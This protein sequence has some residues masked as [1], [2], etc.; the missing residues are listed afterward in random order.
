MKRSV[1]LA[2]VLL[3]AALCTSCQQKAPAS[4]QAAPAYP[5]QAVELVSPAGMASGYD[6]TI[7][8]VSQCLQDTGLVTVPLPVTNKPGEGGGIALRYLSE[9]Q[10]ADDV[11]AVFSPP[12]CLLN[13]NGDT[14]LSYG[15]DTTPIARLITDYGCFAVAADSPYETLPQVMEAIVDDPTAIRVGGTSSLGS[16]DHIQFLKAAQAAGVETLDQIPYTGFEDGGA[17]AQLLGGHVDLISAGISDVVGLVESGDLR[18]LGITAEK[19]VGSGIVAQMPTCVEQGIDATFYNWR[20]LFGPRDMPDYALDYWEQTLAEMAETQEWADICAKYGW[21][22][23][24][25]GHEEFLTF[26][27]QVNR[28]YAALL[29]QIGLL[30]GGSAGDA[31]QEE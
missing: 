21:D 31:G 4:S 14:P 25:L 28:E 26:L 23:D 7:R 13:L 16:M 12:L 3:A 19:R 6:L 1:A 20:G 2:V 24:Y 22:M 9:N 11:V 30:Q 5:R 18:V 8:S 10:G 15:E 27:D 17:P 29:E